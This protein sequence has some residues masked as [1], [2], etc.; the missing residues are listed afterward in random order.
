[1]LLV[2]IIVIRYFFFANEILQ[3]C[4]QF[5]AGTD[6]MVFDMSIIGPS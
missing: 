1:M 2:F 6:E 4:F 5:V 3:K